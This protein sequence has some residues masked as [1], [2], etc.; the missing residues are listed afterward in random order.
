MFQS[1][2]ASGRGR[3][4]PSVQMAPLIDMIFI[5][6]IFFL[7]TT[8]FVRETGIE[9][10]RPTSVTASP[11]ERSSLLVGIS[12]SGT[13]HFEGSTVELVSLRSLLRPRL[14]KRPDRVVVLLVD[15]DAPSGRLVE[16]IDECKLAGAERVAIASRQAK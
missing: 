4:T 15:R 5:L 9:V 16:V 1:I 11:Q 10:T 13:V 7:V 12:A 3:R 14:E 6:L 2:R 8:S